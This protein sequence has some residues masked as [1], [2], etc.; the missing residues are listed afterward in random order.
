MKK[1][2]RW[3]NPLEIILKRLYEKLTK[4]LIKCYNYYEKV[5]QTEKIRNGG[6]QIA[7][8]IEIEK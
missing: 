8:S 4:Y 6:C 2:R 5:P 1:I 3:K 7:W